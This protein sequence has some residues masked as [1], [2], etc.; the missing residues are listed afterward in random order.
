MGAE[1]YLFRPIEPQALLQELRPY[2]ALPDEV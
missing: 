1:K 2:L